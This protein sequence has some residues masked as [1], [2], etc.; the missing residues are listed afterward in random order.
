M[1]LKIIAD[2]CANH[3]GDLSIAKEMIHQAKEVGADFIKFQSW[4]AED[5][6]RGQADEMSKF[7]LSEEAHMEL[8]AEAKKAGIE[9]LTT[10]FN[11][12]SVNFLGSL[13]LKY[14]KVGSAECANYELLENLAK[15]FEHIIVSTGM[16]YDE[17]VIKTTEILKAKAK[18]FALLHCVSKYPIKDDQFN[19]NRINW[20]RTLAPQVGYSDHSAGDDF[21]ASAIAMHIGVDFLER[22]Y[23]LDRSWQTK[24]QPVSVDT[25]GL[26]KI[27]ELAKNP[28]E[29][30]KVAIDN[31][32]LFGEEHR[33]LSEE[34]ENNR[35]FYIG[36]W[37]K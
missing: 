36:R 10:C 28:E 33:Q 32:S 30:K 15:K 31:K 27:I 16:H 37:G 4:K 22:H 34:E 9:F 21:R 20:L 2:A 14:I 25:N 13:G 5:N 1:K 26:K 23:I 7:E 18:N 24:D 29:L 8:M 19:L 35:L 17:E 12:G 6:T 3:K 11:S